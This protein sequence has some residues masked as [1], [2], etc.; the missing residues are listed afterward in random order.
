MQPRKNSPSLE[1]R[2][3]RLEALTTTR[4]RGADLVSM[5][6]LSGAVFL[7]LGVAWWGSESSV[8]TEVQEEPLVSIGL[9]LLLLVVAVASWFGTRAAATIE[10]HGEVLRERNAKLRERLAKDLAQSDGPQRPGRPGRQP[11]A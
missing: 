5:L 1:A 7:G 4:S 10:A 9:S 3:S 8:F 11:V 2:V 6:L